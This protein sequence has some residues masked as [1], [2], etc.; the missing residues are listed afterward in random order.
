M[1]ASLP[2]AECPN[3]DTA[4]KHSHCLELALSLPSSQAYRH[5]YAHPPPIPDPGMGRC[6]QSHR[7]TRFP[8]VTCQASK[9]RPGPGG[10]AAGSS[11]PPNSPAMAGNAPSDISEPLSD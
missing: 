3:A 7:S 2:G 5:I 4:S 11:H 10:E 6:F 1:D 9:G 8:A